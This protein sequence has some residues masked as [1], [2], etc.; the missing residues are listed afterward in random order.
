MTT[1]AGMMAS[2]S[3]IRILTV[4]PSPGRLWTLTLPP[5]FSMFVFTT[6]MPTPRPEMFV[7][8]LAVENPGRKISRVAS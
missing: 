6:S 7:T 2:V 8:A 3:G 1:S 4:M 5:I